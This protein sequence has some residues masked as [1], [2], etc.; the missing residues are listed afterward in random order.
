MRASRGA[1]LP[2]RPTTRVSKLRRRNLFLFFFFSSLHHQLEITTYYLRRLRYGDLLRAFRT[3]E[4]V[5]WIDFRSRPP[6][7][8]CVVFSAHATLEAILPSGG[9]LAADMGRWGMCRTK[10]L[11]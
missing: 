7:L 11:V 6:R 3:H 4:S 10:P 2:A 9:R 1:A 8:I 5:P